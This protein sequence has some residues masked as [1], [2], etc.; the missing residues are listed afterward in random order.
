M[1]FDSPLERSVR[2][3][4]APKEE[5][6]IGVLEDIAKDDLELKRGALLL[7]PLSGEVRECLKHDLVLDVEQCER[8][9]KARRLWN[10]DALRIMRFERPTD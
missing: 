4:P 9:M 10:V 6:A 8:A 5:D 3:L 2:L 1:L 7:H